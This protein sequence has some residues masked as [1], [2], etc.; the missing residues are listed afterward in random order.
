MTDKQK[1]NKF[2]QLQSKELKIDDI[3]KELDSDVKSLRRFLN[4]N[5][6]RSVKGKYQ[7]KKI[8]V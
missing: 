1:L 6:Y 8:Q 3:A 7:K 2:L 5:G 4:K